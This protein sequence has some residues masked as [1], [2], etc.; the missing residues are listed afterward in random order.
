M[1]GR[2][3]A[4]ASLRRIA[5]SDPSLGGSAHDAHGDLLDEISTPFASVRPSLI[6]LT[7]APQMGVGLGERSLPDPRPLVAAPMRGPHGRLQRLAIRLG[8]LTF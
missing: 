8:V 1:R 3:D 7:A 4:R 2:H 6:N 5:H